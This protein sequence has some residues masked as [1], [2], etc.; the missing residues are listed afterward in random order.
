MSGATYDTVV[1]RFAKG[2]VKVGT[3][4]AENTLQGFIEDSSLTDTGQAIAYGA[5]WLAAHGTTVDQVTVGVNPQTAG[6]T[7]YIGP[8]KGDALVVRDRADGPETSRVRAI[9]IA[10]LRRNGQAN[11]VYTVGARR[12]EDAIATERQLAKIGGSMRASFAASTP[13]P[14]PSFGDLATSALP[15][16]TLPIADAD[17]FSIEEPYDRTKPTRF[18]EPAAVIR[19]QCTAES[20]VGSTNTVFALWKITYASGTPTA[21]QL[22]SFSWSGTKR[23][24]QFLCDHPFGVDEA[25]QLRILTAGAHNLAAIQPIAS[26]TN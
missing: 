2:E 10:G 22:Q 4:A 16:I 25:F 1:V 13:S 23:L 17:T 26:S 21:T 3:D 11:W 18:A 9:G 19:F 24:A 8:S 15:T 12:Q 5:A 14:A 6:V 7:P 20:L